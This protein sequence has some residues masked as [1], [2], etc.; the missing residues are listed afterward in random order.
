MLLKY[1]IKLRQAIY[2]LNP[3]KGIQETAFPLGHEMELDPKQANDLLKKDSCWVE[4]R[5]ADNYCTYLRIMVDDIEWMKEEVYQSVS[6][7]LL[8]G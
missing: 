3:N 1:T 7:E 8:I 4:A 6:E 2:G 5:L